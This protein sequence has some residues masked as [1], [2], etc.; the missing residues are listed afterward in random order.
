MKKV[1]NQEMFKIPIA[2]NQIIK[3][4]IVGNLLRS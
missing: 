1:P 3:L 4:E 2:L